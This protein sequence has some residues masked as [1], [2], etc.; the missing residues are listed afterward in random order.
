MGELQHFGWE[1][2]CVDLSSNI[3]RKINIWVPF[4]RKGKATGKASMK[5][6]CKNHHYPWSSSQGGRMTFA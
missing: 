6:S 4:E 1:W 2:K 5:F 3:D